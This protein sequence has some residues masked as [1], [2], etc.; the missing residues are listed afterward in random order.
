MLAY[1]I[2]VFPSSKAIR[3]ENL[4]KLIFLFIEDLVLSEIVARAKIS[5]YVVTNSNTKLY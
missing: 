3:R 2:A 5:S 1:T 4:F